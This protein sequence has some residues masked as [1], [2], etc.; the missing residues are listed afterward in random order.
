MMKKIKKIFRIIFPKKITEQQFFENKLI[1]NDL[2]ESFSKNSEEYQ[3]VLKN[4]LQLIIRDF[5]YSDYD[6]FDQI[7][8][9]K[10]YDSILKMF[11]LNDFSQQ[12]K[13]IIDAGANVGYTSVFFAK[14]LKEFQ[15]FAIEPSP[16]NCEIYQKNTKEFEN[17]KIYPNAL[18]EKPNKYFNL[19]RDFRDGKDW[20]ISTKEAKDGAVKGISIDEIIEENKLDYISL[21]KIDIEGAE[22]FIFKKE[23]KLDFLK[24]TQ[25]IAVEIHDEYDVRETIYDILTENNFFLF[26]SGELTIGINKDFI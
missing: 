13:V 8:I 21:L 15:I 12:Q 4:G 19:D 23:N 16:Q 18:S 7:F 1:N 9:F 26:E 2:I 5:H 17:I 10:E 14:A 24:I 3:V 20:S 6:V 25:I 11:L 22:R